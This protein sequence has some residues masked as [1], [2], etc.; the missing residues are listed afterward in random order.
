MTEVLIQPFLYHTI[1]KHVCTLAR[2][3][4]VAGGAARAVYYWRKPTHYK[5]NDIDIF[6]SS[7]VRIQLVQDWLITAGAE[8]TKTN[9][10]YVTY[11]LKGYPIQVITGSTYHDVRDLLDTFDFTMCQFAMDADYL[12]YTSEA[13]AAVEEKR[14]TINQI[15]IPLRTLAR[16]TKYQKMGF[17]PDADVLRH[18]SEAAVYELAERV[19]SGTEGKYV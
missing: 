6:C 4:W 13:A 8:L 16:V 11:E 3:I 17:T 2:G 10:Y 12:Y 18:L 7:K 5:M 14:L 1:L 9:E 19:K 15:V